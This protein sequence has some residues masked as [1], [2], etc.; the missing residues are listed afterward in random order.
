MSFWSRSRFLPV[1]AF[2]LVTSVLSGDIARAEVI[3]L[4]ASDDVRWAFL[5]SAMILAAGMIGAAL[6][7]RKPK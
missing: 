1:L 3:Y 4:D 6:I 7:L 2:V 5:H